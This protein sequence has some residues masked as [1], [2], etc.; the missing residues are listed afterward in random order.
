MICLETSGA[1]LPAIQQA[2][3]EIGPGRILFGSGGIPDQFHLEWQKIMELESL[4]TVDAF[5]GVVNRNARRLFFRG[6]EA[7][8]RLAASREG[9]SV[10]R[11]PG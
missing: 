10:V 7:V 8:T 1:S 3:E 6:A 2:F 5:Q 4:V 9:L 11:R